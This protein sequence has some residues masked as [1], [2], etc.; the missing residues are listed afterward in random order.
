MNRIV[1][2][3]AAYAAVALEAGL[4]PLWSIPHGD[5]AAGPSLLL[6]LTCFI[7]LLASPVTTGWAA[8]VL[9][10]IADASAS[11]PMLGPHAL[12]F[13]LGAYV[14]LQ[15]RSLVFRESVFTLAFMVLAAGVFAQLGA[16]ALVATR[17]L[18]ITPASGVEGFVAANE[19]VDRFFDVLYTAVAAM[20]VGWLLFRTTPWW[21]FGGRR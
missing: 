4:A 10:L 18:P 11:V 2:I 7:A 20:P 15:L 14:V 21:S 17:A 9:G 8:L 13:L 6:I 12:G 16:V 1:F 5:A 19:L 3:V